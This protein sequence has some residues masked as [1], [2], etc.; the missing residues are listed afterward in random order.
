MEQVAKR[1]LAQ[2]E[3]FKQRFKPRDLE[4]IVEPTSSRGHYR[5]SRVTQPSSQTL[6]RPSHT[7]GSNH[8]IGKKIEEMF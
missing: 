1:T 8:Y 4:W 3:S 6:F 5:L 7:E 2:A